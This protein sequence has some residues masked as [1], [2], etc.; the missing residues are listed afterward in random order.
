[1]RSR[2]TTN[3]SNSIFDDIPSPVIFVGCP[4]QTIP[5]RKERLPL[6]E[7]RPPTPTTIITSPKDKKEK[8]ET[9]SI[10]F[11]SS[12]LLQPRKLR[13]CNDEVND[14]FLHTI[15]AEK[16]GRSDYSIVTSTGLSHSTASP[17]SPE[18]TVDIDRIL[19]ASF[20]PT[21]PPTQLPTSLSS[22]DKL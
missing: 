7:R 14:T 9:G 21:A 19:F 6:P 22:I 13:S 15:P 4:G 2:D 12:S 3:P 20:H 16:E 11:R 17:A 5:Q 10:D 1:M 8:R 18:V